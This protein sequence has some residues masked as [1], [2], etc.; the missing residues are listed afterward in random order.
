MLYECKTNALVD[1]K[2]SSLLL[3]KANNSAKDEAA[4]CYLQDRNMFFN[5][6]VKIVTVTRQRKQLIT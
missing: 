1:I 6:S 4:F 2:D 3:K 5:S